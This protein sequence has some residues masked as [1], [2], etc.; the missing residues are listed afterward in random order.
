MV[1]ISRHDVDLERIGMER[2]SRL[3]N[4]ETEGQLVLKGTEVKRN[5]EQ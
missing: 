5:L 4:D 1:C 3:H 2:P